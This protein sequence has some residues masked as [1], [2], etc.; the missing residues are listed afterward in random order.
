MSTNMLTA[1]F[2][3]WHAVQELNI[4]MGRGKKKILFQIT[5]T[6]S[7]ISFPLTTAAVCPQVL[8]S[9]EI[10]L[11]WNILPLASFTSD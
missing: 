3:H 8:Q 2:S 6:E 4:N 7:N 5:Q 1:S 9:V 11:Q 10:R